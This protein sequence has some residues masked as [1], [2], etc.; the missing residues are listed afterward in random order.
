MSVFGKIQ[1]EINTGHWNIPTE[2]FAENRQINYCNI[3]KTFLGFDCANLNKIWRQM[4]PTYYILLNSSA[5][6]I[7][8]VNLRA[9]MKIRLIRLSSNL[10]LTHAFAVTSKHE[11]LPWARNEKNAIRSN[12]LRNPPLQYVIGKPLSRFLALSLSSS[13]PDITATVFLT[14]WNYR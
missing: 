5:W 9:L 8:K 13:P 6:L 11:Y 1:V 7:F 12:R 10:W 3:D 4:R 2:I 14:L